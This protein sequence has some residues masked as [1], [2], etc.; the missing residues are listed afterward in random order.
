MFNHAEKHTGFEIENTPGVAAA[1]APVR[2]RS[3]IVAR[4]TGPGSSA[5]NVGDTGQR[6]DAGNDRYTWEEWFRLYKIEAGRV[7]P[8]LAVNAQG[9]SVLDF[10]DKAMLRDAHGRNICPRTFGRLSANQL[11]I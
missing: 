8:M 4:D 7:N 3:V 2:T 6:G 1:G 9:S 11:D 10:M 5:G